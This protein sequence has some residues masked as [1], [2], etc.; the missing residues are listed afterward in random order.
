M[1][2]HEWKNLLGTCKSPFA[3]IQISSFIARRLFFSLQYRFA[4]PLWKYPR[5][6]RKAL[7]LVEQVPLNGDKISLRETVE[8]RGPI[9]LKLASGWKMYNGLPDWRESFSDPEQESSLHRWH[10]LLVALTDPNQNIDVGWGLALMRS[11]LQTIGITPTGL[12]GEPYTSGERIINAILFLSRIENVPPGSNVPEELRTA[13]IREAYTLAG[14]IEYSGDRGTGNHVLNNARALF[15]AG[16]SF[17]I[18]SLSRLALQIVRQS[19]PVLI[20]PEGFLRE[21]SSHYHF[22]ITRWVLEML[23]LSGET[24]EKE[25]QE[26]LA[27]WAK[28]LLE[29]CSFFLVHN[30]VDGK[31]QLPLIGDISPDCTPEWLLHLPWSCMAQ[32]MVPSPLPCPTSLSGWARLWGESAILSK[33]EDSDSSFQNF[34][35]SGWLR[36]DHGEVTIIWH[37]RVP[38]MIHK[39]THEHADTLGFVFY[40]SGVPLLIDSGRPTYSDSDPD[41]VYSGSASAHNIPTVDGFDPVLV[42]KSQIL[43]RFYVQN[44]VRTKGTFEKQIFILLLRHEGF[45]RLP[46]ERVGHERL[47]RIGNKNFEI[48]DSFEGLLSHEIRQHFHWD[49]QV[50]LSPVGKNELQIR[51]P[52]G[53]CATLSHS[54][55][56]GCDVS[57]TNGWISPVYGVKVAA[58]QLTACARTGFPSVWR[59]QIRW[60]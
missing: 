46:E 48:L 43:P 31:W 34:S 40:L 51:H 21:G 10:W 24:G 9:K 32:D 17:Q 33:K 11:W 36:L 35:K 16:A 50:L 59:T 44:E 29:R 22:L 15:F 53:V 23:W 8:L 26:T 28:C 57:V 6:V 2:T 14:R 13:L 3:V 56:E 12:A 55:P 47:F 7:R 42:D 1:T 30:S 54:F 39:A 41:Y 45:R 5:S 27:P 60:S 49:P 37:I 58:A 38:E 52:S 4:K 19:L 18:P 20:T 25:M